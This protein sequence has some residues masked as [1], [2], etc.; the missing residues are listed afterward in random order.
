MKNN[1]NNKRQWSEQDTEPNIVTPIR[2]RTQQTRATTS[3]NQYSALTTDTD[4][5]VSIAEEAFLPTDPDN[6]LSDSN[7][8]SDMSTDTSDT[9]HMITMAKLLGL[10]EELEPGS[11]QQSTTNTRTQILVTFR[12]PWV[13]P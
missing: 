4:S 12:L 8:D 6:T 5:E 7:S 3:H 2:D 10:M 13:M 11:T 1:T 9:Y